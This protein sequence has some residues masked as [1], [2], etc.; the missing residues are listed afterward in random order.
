M[1]PAPASTAHDA[2][3]A[4]ILRALEAGPYTMEDLAHACGLTQNIV[5]HTLWFLRGRGEVRQL[6]R[7]RRTGPTSWRTGYELARP[8]PGQRLAQA[9]AMLAQGLT[10]DEAA[11]CLDLTGAET[12]TLAQEVTP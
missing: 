3:R 12:Q 8:S 11:W 1:K 9:R 5:N 4:V 6:R 2:H 10:L 7:F